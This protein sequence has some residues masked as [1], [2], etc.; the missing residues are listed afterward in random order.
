MSTPRV[1]PA[2]VYDTIELVAYAYGGIG[3]GFFALTAEGE[4][5]YGDDPRAAYPVCARGMEQFAGIPHGK[6]GT[7]TGWNGAVAHDNDYAVKR[8]NW[9][10]RRS[11]GTRVP[12]SLWCKELNVVRGS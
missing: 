12:F 2:D 3:R 10:R 1:L 6:R 7:R 11:P 4:H 5:V 8:I 9:R